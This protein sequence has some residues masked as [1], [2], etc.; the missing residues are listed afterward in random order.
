M[1]DPLNPFGSFEDVPLIGVDPVCLDIVRDTLAKMLDDIRSMDN[2]EE[3]WEYVKTHFPQQ[4]KNL[5]REGVVIENSSSLGLWR[6]KMEGQPQDPKLL[7]TSTASLIFATRL[8]GL[9]ND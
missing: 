7:D 3:A 5:E 9:R 8:P 1:I 6:Q 2:M 4:L